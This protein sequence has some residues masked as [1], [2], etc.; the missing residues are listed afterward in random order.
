M[1]RKAGKAKAA[2]KKKGGKKKSA[3][4][5]TPAKKSA[6]KKAKKAKK[7]AKKAAVAQ[8]MLGAA[9]AP[10]PA[11]PPKP[12][13]PVDDEAK[14]FAVGKCVESILD[15]Q[16]PTWT[17][18][19]KV[20]KY[21]NAITI[22]GVLTLVRKCLKPKYDFTIPQNFPAKCTS[23]TETIQQMKIDISDVTKP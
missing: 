11:A 8:V 18:D 17:N 9:A 23:D 15:A 2:G 21:Y 16:H 19:D 4:K 3:A 1:A 22:I 12:A 5:K 6:V 13:L 10:K 20:S 14:L 7:V